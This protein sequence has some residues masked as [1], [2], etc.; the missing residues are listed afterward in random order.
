MEE[1][2]E[3]SG[4]FHYEIPCIIGKRVPRVYVRNGEVVGTQTCE[5][6]E[7]EGF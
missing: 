3:A 6:Y 5:K 2:A 1:L 7:L 4:G